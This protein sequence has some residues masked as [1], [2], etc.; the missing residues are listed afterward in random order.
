MQLEQG[1]SKLM[2]K[3]GLTYSQAS[4]LYAWHFEREKQC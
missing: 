1:I 4:W 2:R 3:Y